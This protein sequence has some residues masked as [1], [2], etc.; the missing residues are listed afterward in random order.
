MNDFTKK[1]RREEDTLGLRQYRQSE[2][3]EYKS[4][5]LALIH[6]RLGN[7]NTIVTQSH[8]LWGMCASD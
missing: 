8:V 4:E 6:G 2:T 1:G 5:R 7:S 3:D